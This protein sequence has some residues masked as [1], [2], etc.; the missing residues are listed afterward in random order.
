MKQPI[1][2]RQN[3]LI[4]CRTEINH[5]RRLLHPF[6]LDRVN[7]QVICILKKWHYGFTA[8][9]SPAAEDDQYLV[10]LNQLLRLS[11]KTVGTTFSIG[12]DRLHRSAQDSAGLI[13]FLNRQECRIDNR[14]L[15]VGHRPAE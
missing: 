8:F 15:A 3:L 2:R 12:N 14:P 5:I 10:F 7:Q 11:G 1:N 13:Q 4:R 6:I 9:R